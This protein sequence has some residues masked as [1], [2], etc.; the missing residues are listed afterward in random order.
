MDITECTIDLTMTTRARRPRLADPVR[1][2]HLQ[3]RGSPVPRPGRLR[4]QDGWTWIEE[5]LIVT[6]CGSYCDDFKTGGAVFDGTYGCPP[7]G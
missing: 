1:H 7:A 5:G 6:F 3:R 4:Q 2:V